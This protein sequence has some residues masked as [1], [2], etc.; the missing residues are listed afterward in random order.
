VV[1]AINK[2]KLH[3]PKYHRVN[4]P[5]RLTEA[6]VHRLLTL[7]ERVKAQDDDWMFPNRIKKGKIMKPG[8]IWHEHILARRIQPIA[9]RLGLP[10]I[11]WRLLRHWGATTMIAA[12]VDIKAAQQ[13]LGHSRPNTL[14]IH[15][16]QV[17]D[18]SADAAAGLLSGQLG[19]VIP[20]EF[21]VN[22]VDV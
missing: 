22:P 3:T 11:T 13:R 17:L 18:E 1:R 12:K 6:D 5:I 16:A 19:Y 7:K 9:D 14:L 4:R 20:A 15:Y 21:A 10:H 8:P 2:G